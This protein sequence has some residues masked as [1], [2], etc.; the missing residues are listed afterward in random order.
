MFLLDKKRVGLKMLHSRLL[1]TD[2]ARVLIA[3]VIVLVV[4]ESKWKAQNEKLVQSS[5]P[6]SDFRF[7]CFFRVKK[8]RM[9]RR[10]SA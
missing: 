9:I 7:L 8:E 2:L 4:M 6:L 3:T 10:F 1:C 5:N